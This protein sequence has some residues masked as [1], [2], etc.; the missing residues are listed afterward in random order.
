MGETDFWDDQDAAQKTVNE[1]KLIKAQIGPIDKV[2]EA[3]EEAQVAYEMAKEGNDKDL[4]AEADQSLFD[5]QSRMDKVELQSLLSGKHDH[6]NAYFTIHAGDGGT[7]ANDWAEMLFRMYLYYFENMGWKVEE[8]SKGF[9]VET[10][11]DHITLHVKG[12]FAFGYLN[13]TVVA[14]A[15][16]FIFFTFQQGNLRVVGF[17]KRDRVIGGSIVM[18]NNFKGQV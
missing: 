2:V 10:G 5:L 3:F 12:P 14:N 8:V 4:L 9:G 11:I 18:D 1:L 16:T 6:R 13:H 17:D 7:E 15:K